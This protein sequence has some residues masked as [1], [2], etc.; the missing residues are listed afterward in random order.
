MSLGNNHRRPEIFDSKSIAIAIL[1][2]A[3]VFICLLVMGVINFNDEKEVV[4]PIDMTVVVHENLDGNEEEPPPEKEVEA[5]PPEPEPVVEKTPPPPPPIKEELPELPP[6]VEAVEKIVEKKPPKKEEPAIKPVEKKKEPEKK[7]EKKEE[8]K[9]ERPKETREE[10]LKRIRESAKNIKITR[11]NAVPPR[12]NGKT[13]RRPADWEKL[14]A[15]GA[16][17]GAKTV[18]SNSENQRC[19]SLIRKAFYSKWNC[20]SW[21]DRLRPVQLSVTFGSGG[22]VE[23][24]R[25]ISSSGDRATDESVLAAAAAVRMVHGLSYEFLSKNRTIIINFT[26]NNK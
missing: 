15:Q 4:I 8:K 24:Y 20:P 7:I 13:E 16:T 2:H 5:P 3:V 21:T 9:P 14:L 26:I 11:P 17:P 6:K 10:R 1:C 23:G 18:V 22:S 25:I 19:L 12:N